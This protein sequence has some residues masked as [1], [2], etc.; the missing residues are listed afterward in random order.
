MVDERKIP[1][2]KFLN[3]GKDNMDHL[4]RSFIVD[5]SFG[6]QTNKMDQ[7]SL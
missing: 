2:R 1:K 7:C 4:W 6:L 5:R 3:N